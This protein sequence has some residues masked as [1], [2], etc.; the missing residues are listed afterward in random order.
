MKPISKEKYDKYNKLVSSKKSFQVIYYLCLVGIFTCLL[1]LCFVKTFITRSVTALSYNENS[2]VDYNVKL[3]PNEYYDTDTLPSGM[4]YIASLIGS[5]NLNFDYDFTTNSSI[6]YDAS[7]Y[8]EAITRVYGKDNKNVVFEKKETLIPLE[9]ISKKSITNNNFNKEVVLDYDHFNNLA[10]AFKASYFL[11]YDS[12]VTVVLHVQTHGTNEKLPDD[13]N[14]QGVATVVIP[15][16]EQTINITIDSKNI[17]NSGIIVD[18]NKWG[19][20]NPLY[21]VGF[22]LFSASDIFAIYCIVKIFVKDWQ[23]RSVYDKTLKRILRDYDSIIAN[24]ENNVEENDYKILNLSSFDEL[25][26]VHDNLG[27]PILF[28]DVVPG[29]LSYFTIVS[30]D[31]LYRYTLDA[32]NLKKRVKS[33]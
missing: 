23:S 21:F 13:I 33:K 17:N 26:D 31:L 25:R 29:E 27:I 12:D 6:D 32:N 14:S 2:T 9:K 16:T 5:I 1:L 10:R 30:D 8:V 22:L 19:N 18:N 20:I 28:S 15:L 24:I 7:Y 11:N 3:K 4:D